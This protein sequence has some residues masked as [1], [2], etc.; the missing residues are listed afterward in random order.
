MPYRLRNTRPHYR[1]VD[2]RTEVAPNPALAA[3]MKRLM[4]ARK[5]G[6]IGGLRAAMA[7][8]GLSIGQETVANAVNGLAK[9]RLQSLNK[10][11]QFFDVTVDQLLGVEEAF[12]PFSA[13]LQQRVLQ[14]DEGQL[15]RLEGVMRAHLGMQVESMAYSKSTVDAEQQT[16]GSGVVHGSAVRYADPSPQEGGRTKRYHALEEAALPADGDG[17]TESRRSIPQKSGGRGR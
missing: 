1:Y 10:I 6:G 16:G 11:A 3:N 2:K 14:M 8:H 13:D 9:N 12:W 17:S 4:Q 5:I 7:A 15:Q